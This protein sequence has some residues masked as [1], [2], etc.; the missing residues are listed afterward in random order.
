MCNYTE[1]YVY[2]LLDPREPGRYFS[3]VLNMSFLFK[4]YYFGKGKGRRV[5]HHEEDVVK[6]YTKYRD[7]VK[8]YNKNKK[9]I[10]EAVCLKWII[11]K[12]NLNEN[13]A[14]DI[15]EMCIREYGL[16]NLTNVVYKSG[17]ISVPKTIKRKISKKHKEA[18][19]EASKRPESESHKQKISESIKKKY[20]ED[21]EYIKKRKDMHK[22]DKFKKTMSDS[23]IERYKTNP[24]PS[25]GRKYTEEQKQNRDNSGILKGSSHKMSK[26][27][28]EDISVIFQLRKDGLTHQKIADIFKIDRTMIGKILQR[29]SWRHCI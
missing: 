13:T 19:L 12:D 16:E 4:P 22:S 7:G 6:G 11:V 10:E 18:L 27:K 29:K 3:Q 14:L 25:K 26:L 17:A 1:H 5:L 9:I 23:Q 2:V 8:T 28:E 15:E 20:S 21:K 24:S